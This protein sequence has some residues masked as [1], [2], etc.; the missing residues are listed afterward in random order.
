M[1]AKTL[2]LL[3]WGGLLGLFSVA[4]CGWVMRRE[5]KREITCAVDPVDTSADFTSEGQVRDQGFVGASLVAPD[6]L[7]VTVRGGNAE[8]WSKDWKVKIKR[9]S[10]GAKQL[11]S[12]VVGRWSKPVAQPGY[13]LGFGAEDELDIL[14]VE[15]RI[16]L[17]LSEP[18]GERAGV[19]LD[20]PQGKY[21]FEFDDALHHTPL[22]QLNE[23]GYAGAATRRWAYLSYYLGDGGGLEASDLPKTVEL[24]VVDD[25]GAVRNQSALAVRV[26]AQQ[27]ADA[28]AA[29]GEVDLSTLQAGQRFFL[30]VPKVGRTR[31]TNVG[32]QGP[33]LAYTVLMS[34][35]VHNRWGVK[36]D[37][38]FT[39]WPRPADHTTV[40]TAEK[41]SYDMFK[42]APPKQGERKLV[43]GHH[44]AGDFDQRP[45]HTVVPQLLMRAYSFAPSVFRDDELALPEQKNGVPDILDEALWNIAAWEQLQ[46]PDGG[47]RAGVESTR[48]PWGI[49]FAHQDELDYW[50]FAQDA[51]VTARAAGLFAQASRLLA[52]YDK[53]RAD[54][55]AKR[56][57]RAFDWAEKHDAKSVFALYA[58]SALYRLTDDARYKKR[59]EEHW[60][61]IGRE[62]AFNAFASDQLSWSDYA[63]DGRTMTDFF[64]DYLQ[65]SNPDPGIVETA[66]RWLTQEANRVAARVIDSEHG[67]RNPRRRADTIGWGSGTVMG[68]YLD[69]VFAALRLGYG[70]ANSRQ[71]WVDAV[72]LSADYVLGANPAGMV[73]F[74]GV[75]A[76]RTPREPLHLDSLAWLK[77]GK[78]PVPGIP[79]Y[80]PTT[81]LPQN[82]WYKPGLAVMHPKFEQLPRMRRYVDIRTFVVNN[83]FTVWECQAPH[84]AHFA[85]L[86]ALDNIDI[87]ASTAK[88][89]DAGVGSTSHPD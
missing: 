79:V 25:R 85:L 43:G 15:H 78:P 51:N 67:H 86:H 55:L 27:D 61:A 57:R 46:E 10:S 36:L 1:K 40:Y 28:G 80:G 81:A 68:R 41:K 62:G 14:W 22:I 83:E 16:A 75:E 12:K 18:L 29:V 49:Y 88:A 13:R 39:K 2:R 63:K 48:H 17:R 9:G 38:A 34:G 77:K 3:K 4:A 23:L 56:A 37:A 59:F 33:K 58:A 8:G 70:D 87:V 74:T 52:P 66:K 44:D 35:L 84:A 65:A 47:V 82:P 42:D 64:V 60:R 21:E 31:V 76:S 53:A 20:H 72:S 45:S 11:S 32:D 6:L 50:T 30:R 19:E 5:I 54:K 73:Y 69:P 26:R 7:L 89:S 71:R 24:N